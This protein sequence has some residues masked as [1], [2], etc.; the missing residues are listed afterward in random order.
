MCCILSVLFKNYWI[1][2]KNRIK[3]Y[4]TVDNVM[5]Y[6]KCILLY[7]FFAIY[8]GLLY[9]AIL[10][11]ILGINLRLEEIPLLVGAYLLSWLLG[12]LMP[13]SPGGIGIREAALTLFLSGHFNTESVLLAIVIYRVINTIGDFLG[14]T[15]VLSIYIRKKHH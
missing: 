13:G 8:T 6:S 1:K 4:A 12:F 14:F 15:A 10:K 11:Y 9:V 3:E 7:M 2:L 5:S